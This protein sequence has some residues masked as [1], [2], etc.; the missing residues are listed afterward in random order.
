MILG[1]TVVCTASRI[2]RP[3]RSGYIEAPIDLGAMGG[4]HG[5]DQRNYV[6]AG[7][8]VRLQIGEGNGHIGLKGNNQAIHAG[9]HIGWIPAYEKDTFQVFRA[10][11]FD[12]GLYGGDAG[13]DDQLRTYF[14]QPHTEQTEEGHRRAAGYGLNPDLKKTDY[15]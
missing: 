4:D 5:L 6:S 7:K 8:M 9:H 11:A 15:D 3:A 10:E 14:P 12:T 2:S 1:L 13:T